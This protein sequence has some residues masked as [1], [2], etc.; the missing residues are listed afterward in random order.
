MYVKELPHDVGF[1]RNVMLVSPVIGLVGAMSMPV[2]ELPFV[3]GCVYKVLAV[4]L[5]DTSR[6]LRYIRAKE[7]CFWGLRARYKLLTNQYLRHQSFMRVNFSLREQTEGEEFC[8]VVYDLLHNR[9]PSRRVYE[10]GEGVRRLLDCL[11]FADPLGQGP[12]HKFGRGDRPNGLR[13]RPGD[14]LRAGGG[15]GAL[16]RPHRRAAGEGREGEKA[17]AAAAPAA[18]EDG[19]QEGA[20]REAARAEGQ[21]QGQEQRDDFEEQRDEPPLGRGRRL[22]DGHEAKSARRSPAWSKR[23]STRSSTSSRWSSR[24]SAAITWEWSLRAIETLEFGISFRPNSRRRSR[25]AWATR[26]V[27]KDLKLTDFVKF[28]LKHS[29]S[30]SRNQRPFGKF[31]ERV[32]PTHKVQ[33]MTNSVMVFCNL[34]VPAKFNPKEGVR[35]TQIVFTDYVRRVVDKNGVLKAKDAGKTGKCKIIRTKNTGLDDVLFVLGETIG[36]LNG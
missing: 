33:P 34:F 27:P 12:D 25:W 14:F 32:T 4:Y 9:Q 10:A 6:A 15:V 36:K 35:E 18:A 17:A 20:P 26:S 29:Y 8:Y 1:N 31:V 30:T 24:R 7:K 23:S 5:P 11:C 2:D 19:L 16:L 21:R 22:Q 3:H 13:V 28:T